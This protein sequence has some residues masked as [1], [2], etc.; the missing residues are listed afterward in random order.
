MKAC[1]IILSFQK[2]V[3]SFFNMIGSKCFWKPILPVAVCCRFFIF[4]FGEFSRLKYQNRACIKHL[5][6]EVNHHPNDVSP[7][8][9]ND[10]GGAPGGAAR[11]HPP[12]CEASP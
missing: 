7:V 1:F 12:P 3:V 6:G 2:S 9:R 11:R 10:A 8:S 5:T 4:P